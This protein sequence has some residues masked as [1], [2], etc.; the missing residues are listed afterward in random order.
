MNNV[1]S[2]MGFLP[3]IVTSFQLAP[4]SGI[5]DSNQLQLI[6]NSLKTTNNT[7]SVWR[8]ESE[9]EIEKAV[10]AIV[11]ESQHLDA[12]DIIKLD[13]EEIE[14]GKLELTNSPGKTP[15]KEFIQN[16]CDIVK[17]DYGSLGKVAEIIINSFKDKKDTR[18]TKSQLKK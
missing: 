1:F 11:S 7:L 10:L 9:A 12:I 15:F 14:R 13:P 17:L 2:E 3:N 5:M 16:H 8:V 4:L 18:Y 6:T